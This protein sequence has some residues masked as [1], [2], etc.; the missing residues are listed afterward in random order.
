[1]KGIEGM[2]VEAISAQRVIEFDYRRRHRIAEPHTLGIN[3]SDVKQLLTYQLGGES[4]SGPLP[5]WRRFEVDG[6]ENLASRAETFPRRMA[7]SG[8]HARWRK[9]IAFVPAADA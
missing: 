8:E 5:D 1:M 2:L 6:I 7:R 4:S 9:I 3:T